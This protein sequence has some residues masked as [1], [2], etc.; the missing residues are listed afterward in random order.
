MIFGCFPPQEKCEWSHLKSFVDQYNTKFGKVYTRSAC[1]D[2]EER[3][4]KAP[5][6]LLEA[7]GE[8]SIVL[9]H[10]SVVW[11]TKHLSD[12][13]NEHHLG[14]R[15]HILLSDLFQDSVY[16][17]AV[18][19][20]SLKG[21]TKKEVERFAEQIADIVLSDVINAKSQRG[22]GKRKPIPWSFRHFPPDERDETFPKTGIRVE[23]WERFETSPGIGRKILEQFETLPGVGLKV[24]E[25]SETFQG[26]E[27]AKSGYT[28]EFE[29]LAKDAAEK[30]AEYA[31]SM[32][33]LLV[34]FY[35]D[36]PVALS[37]EDIIAII[38]SAQLP[39]LIDQV[40]LGQPEWVSEYDYEIAWERVR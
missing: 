10:K 18:D 14:D 7:P 26:V 35:G 8:T 21:K 2:V 9:E 3:N 30:F 33:L 20:E 11:P 37:D 38:Q 39:E 31:N 15:L 24:L 23:V 4:K 19:A 34:Q 27:R 1:L 25:P 13:H 28:E 5:E 17:L 29:R 6:L 12:H 40:W 22:I 32:K 36:S 16:Q